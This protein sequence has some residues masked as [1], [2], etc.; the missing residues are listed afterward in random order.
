MSEQT[1]RHTVDSQD[2]LQ[3]ARGEQGRKDGENGCRRTKAGEEVIW[4]K[5]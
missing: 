4:L 2:G 3:E 1:G 5:S